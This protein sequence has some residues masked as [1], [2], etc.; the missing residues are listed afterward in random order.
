[1]PNSGNDRP[2]SG[3]R[4]RNPGK[5]PPHPGQIIGKRYQIIRELGRGGFGKTYLAQ[6]IEVPNNPKCVIKQLQ[7]RSNRPE[8]WRDAKQRFV[9]EATVQQRLGNHEQIPKLLSYF[10]ENQEFYLIQEFI[11]GEELQRL[12][13]RQP[14]SEI[15]TIALLQDVLRILDF[16]HKTNVI[17]RDI[18]PS[19]LIRRK[20]DGKFV[21][22]D[23]GAVKEITT[24][25]LDS[26]GQ[27]FT[28]T[29]GTQGFMPPEQIAGKPTYSSDIYALGQTAIYALTGR[30]P[31]EFE[32]EVDTLPNW[33]DF[34][35]L[36]PELAAIIKKMISPRCTERYRSA[37]EVLQDLQPLQKIDQ[38]IGGRYRIKRYL[39][40]KQGIYTYR[41]DNLRRHYQS[42]CAIKEIK[43]HYS[44][45]IVVQTAE[46]RFAN[47]L[48]ILERLSY[49]P[50]IPQLWD[51]FEENEAFYLVEEY[52][53]GESLAQ[54]LQRDRSL[55]EEQVIN[56][57]RSALEVLAFIHQHRVLHK[58]INPSNLIIRNSDEQV[59]LVNFG[60]LTEIAQLPITRVDSTQPLGIEI[61]MP[62]EQIAGRPTFSSDIYALGLTVIEALTGIKADK[63]ETNQKTGEVS[64][65]EE[66]K[67][68]RRLAK[69]L[70]KMVNLYVG[71]RYQSADKVLNDLNKITTLPSTVSRVTRDKEEPNELNNNPVQVAAQSKM[72]LPIA[73][74]KR[75]NWLKPGYILVVL[76]GITVLLG[77]I[78]WFFP[79]FRP[80]YYWTQGRQQLA[81]YPETAIATFDKAIDLQPHSTA[82]WIGRGDGLYRLERFPEALIAY[83]EAI[84][85]NQNNARAWRGRGDA[86]Y[87]LER[88]T[89][90]LA[91]F[92]KALQLQPNNAET[93]NRK[94]R[95]LYKLERYQEAVNAQTEALELEPNNAQA[96]SD[97]GIALIGLGKY[98][99]ALDAFNQAQRSEPLDP[100]FWQNKA[101]ALQYLNRPQE[102]TR[103]YQEA[104]AAYDQVLEDRPQD[105]FAWLD[106]GNVLSQLQRHQD[107][108]DSYEKGIEINSD[109]HLA[110]LGKGN[111]LF[112]LNK[113][114]QALAAFDRA[115]EI[116]PE[117]FITWHNRGSLLRD[118]LGDL[119]EAIASYDKA[120]AINPNFYHAWRD[121][122]FALAK[123]GQNYQAIESF[124]RATNLNPND[125]QAWVGRGIALSSLNKTNEALAAFERAQEIQP[126]D[127]FVWMNKGS[128]LEGANQYN[129]ACEAYRQA[130]QVNPTF[131]PAIEALQR[132]GC[133]TS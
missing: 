59:V 78:E 24:L 106:R 122:G 90:A 86:L 74:T 14:L 20:K 31:L 27:V 127:L 131:S 88:F 68:S 128:A 22:I 126:N 97:L 39:G 93:L 112:A 130:R 41:A 58:D 51:H 54:K 34:G 80:F 124:Q 13:E 12:V 85:L 87:R 132:L 6:N 95:A 133:K 83:D 23:F 5:R 30:S 8:V 82:A 60:V 10:E 65:R 4:Q 89:A 121:K 101:L 117:S 46:R 37:I 94:G 21:L 16:V 18:K 66:I 17:H 110:W 36:S 32:E 125:Y 43:L 109:S 91:S 108:L 50:Q 92:D 56:L 67:V 52:I 118:A 63:L 69:I 96:L 84:Q 113:P 29:I 70:D 44:D 107:A 120:V 62:P 79:T 81:N 19:N 71:K 53:A 40:G 111:A 55:G 9:Q 11:E 3:A 115:L 116:R 119:P 33:Q 100:R 72:N 42:P 38:V 49:H 35:R 26:Q 77:S 103:V 57:L 2:N 75:E 61:Y 73:S 102:A 47:E 104:L 76:A 114:D 64:W 99:E 45:P 98:Q 15:Q 7:P 105:L 48:A 123:S 129:E 1:M 25:A 28:Q